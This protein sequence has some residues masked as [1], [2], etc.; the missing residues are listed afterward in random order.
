MPVTICHLTKT[1]KIDHQFIA[2]RSMESI[3]TGESSSQ[4]LVMFWC[5]DK[6]W[7]IL[8]NNL[9][10]A[11]T[12]P[13]FLFYSQGF[14]QVCC[15]LLVILSIHSR[16]LSG[17]QLTSELTPSEMERRRYAFSEKKC[18]I[19][20]RHWH[21]HYEECSLVHFQCRQMYTGE[22]ETGKPASTNTSVGMGH[23]RRFNRGFWGF[24]FSYFNATFG[25]R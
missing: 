8:A 10:V 2:N 19:E 15:V 7:Y 9:Q 11:L 12:M 13:G 23:M 16:E 24:C 21:R 17:T 22:S 14:A 4:N 5:G 18:I 1:C 6:T 25:Y 3:L 20:S